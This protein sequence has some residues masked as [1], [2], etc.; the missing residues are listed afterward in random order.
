MGPFLPPILWIQNVTKVYSDSDTQADEEHSTA[1]FLISFWGMC[2]A[3]PH[4]TLGIAEC[5][6]R[7]SI[8]SGCA[9]GC[10]SGGK[11]LFIQLHR[12]KEA[13]VA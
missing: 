13:I 6:P 4:P 8:P 3:A 11:E 1:A 12:Y 2:S 9:N 10:V 7:G 5:Q